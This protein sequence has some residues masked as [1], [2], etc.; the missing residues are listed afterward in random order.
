L[1]ATT[2]S[3]SIP[4]ARIAESA[5]STQRTIVSASFRHGMTTETRGTE[6]MPLF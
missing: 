1:S 2:T 3:P 5:A 6:A 4:A